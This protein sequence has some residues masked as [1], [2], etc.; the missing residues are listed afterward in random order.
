[1]TQDIH[2]VVE[3]LRGQVADITYVMLAAARE[4]AQGTGGNVVAVLLGHHAEGLTHDLAA[5][6]TLN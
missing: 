3:H 2:V 1:M 6:H 4:L 5:D